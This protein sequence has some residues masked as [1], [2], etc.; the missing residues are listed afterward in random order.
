MK[1]FFLA[2]TRLIIE[3]KKHILAIFRISFQKIDI[4]N[5]FTIPIAAIFNFFSTIFLVT[6]QSMT[7]N[8][9][10]LEIFIQLHHAKQQQYYS[11]KF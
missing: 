4:I 8:F 6:L 5:D 2:V 10:S 1:I 7:A 3:K 11:T 9:N